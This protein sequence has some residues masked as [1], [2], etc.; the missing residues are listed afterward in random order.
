M[1]AD[2][3]ARQ[4]HAFA[5]NLCEAA[6]GMRV[7]TDGARVVDVRGDPEDVFSRGHIC[8]KGPA[9]RELLDDPDR[10]RA[11]VRRVGSR[12]EPIGWDEAID[13]VAERLG[14]IIARDGRDAV[15]LY[16]GNPT[17]HSHR[18]S[19]GAQ[20]VT[21]ALG[22]KNRFDPNS[23]DSAPRL[24][25]CM[26][27]YGDI[28]AI[29]VPDIDRTDHLL[30]LGANPA[31]SNGSMM[32]L[33]D[34]RGRL[35]GLRARGGRL[36]LV[37]PRRTE[38]A[39]LA[40]EHH[41]LR[42]GGDA[43]LLL[44]MLQVLFAEGLVDEGRVERVASG[45][46][47]LRALAARFPP[48]RVSAAVGIAPDAIRALARPLASARR[49]VV[50]GRVGT[51]QNPFGPAASWLIEAINVVT[52]NFDREGGAMFASPAADVGRLARAFLGNTYGRFRS[53][54]RGLPELLGA[55]PSAVMA[56]EMETPGPGQIRAFICFAGN[57]V[58][59]TPNGERLAR[60]LA[61]LEFMVAIDPYV[62]ET[63]RLAHVILPPAH[64]FEVGNYDLILLGLAVRNV[65]R[66]SPAIL[67]REGGALDDWEILAELS[68]RLRGV[69]AKAARA[70]RRATKDLPDRV[71]DVLLR[72][73]PYRLSLAAIAEAPH[74]V[75][76]GALRP[77]REERVR[78]PD[79]KVRL[80]PPIFLEDE[81]RIAR[82]IDEHDKARESG[83][84]ALIGRR[85]LRSNNSWM[86]NLP[87]LT[88]GPSRT[89]LLMHP[90]DAARL[91]LAQGERVR[92]ESRVGAV[93]AAL[94]VTSDVMPGVVSLPHGFGHEAAKGTLR[95]AGSIEGPNM[96]ALTDD[97]LVEPL[98]GAS[99]LNGFDVVVTRA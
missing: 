83:R 97:L 49:A 99:V 79:G 66:H 98:I 14:A 51:C 68:A 1:M 63:T 3:M 17:V 22:S 64:V 96:N 8:P 54:V 39:A 56:E 86:H 28:A 50:Y 48:E 78:T 67:P 13:L 29:P 59:S 52:G 35:R 93:H 76:L 62:N 47:D 82:W 70:L 7:T 75:D 24:F 69:P 31:A 15:G 34:A 25:A 84:L 12:W 11:P 33:G 46:S 92:V 71:V 5:C 42:P 53:R 45:L 74:G 38:T 77:S 95:V 2:A 21:A 61:E 37:D 41:F 60:A 26:H 9:L 20:L 43:P 40:D 27:V 94:A 88:K 81:P 30:V 90:D 10:L 91:G 89:Q 73:G 6:C 4:E 85:H 58:L 72:A 80:A 23:Q 87:S 44:A 57:P 16:V 18:A 65:A 36:V 55:L 32:A 19:L